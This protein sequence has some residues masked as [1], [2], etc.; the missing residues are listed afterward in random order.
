MKKN[1]Y[2][3]VLIISLS[4]IFPCINFTSASVSVVPQ[5]D[6][7]NTGEYELDDFLSVAVN[8][9]KII[10]GVVGSLTLLMFVYGGVMLMIS[11][12][13]SE[14][15]TK[16]KGILLAAVVGLIIIFTSYIIIKF[17]MSSLGVTWSGGTEPITKTSTSTKATS[18][19]ATK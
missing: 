6:K 1:K 12:G 8:V 3:L 10:L 7:Y 9:S 17:V 15:V 13:N 11:S 14:K 4:L 16:A 5:G 2:I 18:T 19:T